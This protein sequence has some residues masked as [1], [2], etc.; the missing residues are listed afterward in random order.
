MISESP[1]IDEGVTTEI[2]A[3]SVINVEPGIFVPGV[4][5]ANIE[6]TV[7]VGDNEIEQIN[8]LDNGLFI[9]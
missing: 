1:I 8:E 5:P 9:I 2:P 4:G 3:D 7:Y 6:N